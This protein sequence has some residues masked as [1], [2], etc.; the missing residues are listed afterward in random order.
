MN[1]KEAIVLCFT[2]LFKVK[3][4]VTIT[5]TFGMVMLLSGKWNPSDAIQTLYSGIYGSVMTYYFT[6]DDKKKQ[7]T[8]DTEEKFDPAPVKAQ[9]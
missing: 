5:L 9:E 8:I 3:S 2:N 4:I 7:E 6:K 1:I